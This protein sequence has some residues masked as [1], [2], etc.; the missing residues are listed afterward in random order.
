M[1]FT[2]RNFGLALLSLTLVAAT[3][4]PQAAFAAEQ[5][6]YFDNATVS[7]IALQAEPGLALDLGEL[8]ADDTLA[9][10]SNELDMP[11]TDSLHQ[12][13]NA[14]SDLPSIEMNDDMHCLATA[15]Y[16]ESRGEPLEGQLAVAQV[17]LNRVE[18]RWADSICG[19]VYQPRQFSF[20]HDRYSDTPRQS[21][22]WKTAKAIAL[23]AAAGEWHD[24]SKSATH[25]HATRVSPGWNNLVRVSRHGNHVFYRKR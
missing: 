24:V 3:E 25:F 11:R 10:G 16:F 9:L 8:P 22:A 12:L 19:V 1:K 2:L 4:L 5:T 7:S 14:V 20:T 23:I 6:G 21:N 15:I 17:I 18:Q 13:V